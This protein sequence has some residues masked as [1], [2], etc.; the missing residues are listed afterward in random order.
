MICFEVSLNGQKMCTA[1]VAGPEAGMTAALC[2]LTAPELPNAQFRLDVKGLEGDTQLTWLNDFGQVTVGD[3]LTI[4]IA[5]SAIVDQPQREAAPV[6]L[7][8]SR[9]EARD[10]DEPRCGFCHRRQSTHRRL[11][12]GPQVFICNR[13]VD[14]CAGILAEVPRPGPETPTP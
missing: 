13:C 2:A 14:V 8:I 10:P 1:G 3:T 9:E 12:A 6:P 5:E 11:I 4:R 7:A